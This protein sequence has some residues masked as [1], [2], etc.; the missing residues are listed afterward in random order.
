MAA[1]QALSLAVVLD[2]PGHLDISDRS[3]CMILELPDCFYR[4]GLAPR[5]LG[6][7]RSLRYWWSKS[8]APEALETSFLHFALS[9]RLDKCA[10][11]ARLSGSCR[12]VQKPSPRTREWKDMRS[13]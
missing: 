10:L 12:W 13:G 9:I 5:G 4:L 8:V 2:P 3:D 11:A 7:G 6:N 1:A